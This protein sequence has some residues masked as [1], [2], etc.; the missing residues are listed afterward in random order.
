MGCAFSS[1]QIIVIDPNGRSRNG[2]SKNNQNHGFAQT[3][4]LHFRQG[5][6][7]KF[8]NPLISLKD[9]HSLKALI[10]RENPLVELLM[11]QQLFGSLKPKGEMM[12]F[13]WAN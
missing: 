5:K 8:I 7:A 12:L 2:S 3:L 10:D 13:W 11:E 9:N 1:T 4:L 6:M